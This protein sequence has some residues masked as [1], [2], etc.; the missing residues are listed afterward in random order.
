[1]TV[2]VLVADPESASYLTDLPDTRTLVLGPNLEL[3]AGADAA[4][5]FVPGFLAGAQV[6]QVL[7]QLP[8]LRLIQLQ[9]AGAEVWTPHVPDGVV[10]CTARGAHGGSTA[11]WAVGAM[12]ASLRLFPFFHEAQQAGTWSRQAT[13]ELDGK[14]VLLIGA[15]DLGRELTARLQP[16]NVSVTHC[17]RTARDGVYGIDQ[18][19]SL[20]PEQ[21]IV[22]LLLPLTAESHH[23][24][25]ARFLAAMPAGSLLVNAARGPVVDTEALVDELTSGRLRAALDVTD[26]EPLPDG[27]PLFGAPG[28]LLTP[29]VAGTVPGAKRRSMAVV[30]TQLERYLAG[31]ELLFTVGTRGY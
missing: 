18:V 10:L 26:P 30:R 23:L 14:R 17:A 8:A 11:E 4:E 29:H 27:H 19:H 1:M 24:V 13:D 5:V 25:D 2:T 15:G 9:T 7:A 3:P 20:L 12:I 22:V 28:L 16:F 6:V 21:D 31:E